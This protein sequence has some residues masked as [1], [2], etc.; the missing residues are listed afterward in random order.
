M[1]GDGAEA[2][3]M[4]DLMSDAWLAF[5][6]TSNPA[7]PSL[8]AWPAFDLERRATMIFDLPSRV[9]DDPRGEERRFVAQVPYLQPGT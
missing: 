3:R 1:V 5:A 6:H 7:A 8:P 2:Q 4:A 9:V